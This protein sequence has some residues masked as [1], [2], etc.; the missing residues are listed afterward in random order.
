MVVDMKSLEFAIIGIGVIIAI[1]ALML[2]LDISQRAKKEEVEI[3]DQQLQELIQKVDIQVD[4]TT[5]L[6]LWNAA[7]AEALESLEHELSLRRNI[8]DA[9]EL[10]KEAFGDLFHP[11]CQGGVW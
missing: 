5:S 7:L 6:E 9:Q 10:C 1:V 3:L 8:Y 11:A 2:Q 4:R